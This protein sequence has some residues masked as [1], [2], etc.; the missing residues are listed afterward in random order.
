[1]STNTDILRVKLK[2]YHKH[3][4]DARVGTLPD[5]MTLAE[6]HPDYR[7]MHVYAEGEVILKEWNYS[8]HPA[9]ALF[10]EIF[11]KYPCVCVKYEV[12]FGV[13]Q[14][15]LYKETPVK[16]ALDAL[17]VPDGAIVKIYADHRAW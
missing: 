15:R 14:S 8:H 13:L 17:G 4:K 1:M 7:E 2:E 11:E 16:Q 12:P 6:P 3:I 5:Q 10:K 9:G